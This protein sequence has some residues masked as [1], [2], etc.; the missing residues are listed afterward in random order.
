MGQWA[1][2]TSARAVGKASPGENGPFPHTLPCTILVMPLETVPCQ[3]KDLGMWILWGW[4][5]TG[6]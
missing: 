5:V 4:R 6:P 2:R 1:S 3:D